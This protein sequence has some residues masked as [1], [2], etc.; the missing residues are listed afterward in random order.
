M[1]KRFLEWMSL[2]K[3]LHEYRKSI[4]HVNEGDIWW[5]SIGE[6]IGYEINGKSR[7]LSRPVLILKKLSHFLYFAIPLT[8]KIKTGTWYVSY[9]HGDSQAVACLHQARSID[10]RRFHSRLGELNSTD[11]KK[12]KAE[13]VKLYG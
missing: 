12:I 9:Q 7:L 5:V 13:F 8:T 6:N 3:A 11:F 1:I 10:Y 2:K 4:P